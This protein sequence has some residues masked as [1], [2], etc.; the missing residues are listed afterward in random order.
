VLLLTGTSLVAMA[1]NLIG[2][3]SV[4]IFVGHC[5][6]L[7]FSYGYFS[8][9]AAL[10]FAVIVVVWQQRLARLSL[11]IAAAKG[12]YGVL[13]TLV[14]VLHV[15][16]QMG[17]L[18][19]WI[20][21]VLLPSGR[22]PA[23]RTLGTFARGVLCLLAAWQ[24]LQAYP[25]AG[26]Q[27]AIGTFLCIPVYS[28]CLHDAITTFTSELWAVRAR[29]RLSPRT[30]LLVKP[31]VFASILYLLAA[32]W[33]APLP[34]WRYYA[35][36]PSLDLPGAH[37]LHLPTYQADSYRELTH[38]VERE[39]DTFIT[40]LHSLYFWT[41]KAPPTHLITSGEIVAA[42]RRAK[43]PLIVINDRKVLINERKAQLP[44]STGPIGKDPLTVYIDNTFGEVKRLGTFR[45][46]APKA[47]TTQATSGETSR[48][49]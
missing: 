16:D 30:G 13:G 15:R 22:D 20:W 47:V 2:G 44:K 29:F 27:V 31:L 24:G 37:Y 49:N 25:V 9:A 46:L 43:H 4:A 28:L 17:H 45:I 40:G 18:L 35:S 19:P 33:C 38:Y 42:L 6:P 14:L 7:R 39:G 5:L 34:Q 36:L 32:Q 10:L 23:S 3:P 8:A 48:V 1:H 12:L 21:L 26:S 41:R 11:A